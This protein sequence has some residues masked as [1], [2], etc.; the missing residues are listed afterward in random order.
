MS[1]VELHRTDGAVVRLPHTGGSVT[2]DRGAA[3]RRTCTVTV[4]DTSLI[5]MTPSAEMAICGA[6]LRILRG[7]QYADGTVETVPLGV[8]RVDSVSGDP[9]FGPVAITGSGLEAIIGDDRFMAPYSTRANTAAVTAIAALVRESIPGIVVV[10]SVSDEPLGPRTWDREANRWDA[11]RELATAVG[12]DVY[13]DAD[14]QV[15]VAELPDLLTAPIVWSVD[16]G[17][18]GVLISAERG[19][20]REGMHNVVVASGENTETGS[21][22]V[23]ATAMDDDPGSPTYY[24]GPFGRV[25]RFYSSPTLTTVSLAQGAA[26]K[27]LRDSVKLASTADITAVP[28]PCL[29][30]GDVIRVT[31]GSGDRELHQV[32]S[33]T[34]D[35][36]GGS[37]TL[38]TISAKEDA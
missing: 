8:F 25:P 6:R 30:P 5:P 36:A 7:I 20:S 17:P 3:V 12:A 9:D 10:A 27:L 23:S 38:T 16:A 19:Y 34:I 2:V 11:V 28:N 4:S 35:L 24:L 1:V 29:E 32:Q 15:V 14:G 21:A 13:V 31:Y 18:G 33:Y 26:N 37:F 22:P